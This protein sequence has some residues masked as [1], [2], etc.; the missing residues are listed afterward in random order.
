MSLQTFV[1]SSGHVKLSPAG[2]STEKVRGRR[3]ETLSQIISFYR[4]GWA[5]GKKIVAINLQ[6]RSTKDNNVKVN[7]RKYIK[8]ESH[9]TSKNSRINQTCYYSSNHLTSS[10]NITRLPWQI[11]WFKSRWVKRNFFVLQKEQLRQIL[12]HLCLHVN[13]ALNQNTRLFAS[14]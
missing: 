1:T 12:N 6:G 2:G 4:R 11:V 7:I 14:L 8:Q 10:H 13:S 3:L 9:N 5:G